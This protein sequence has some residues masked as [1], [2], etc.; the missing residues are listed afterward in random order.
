MIKW[1]QST[2][3]SPSFWRKNCYTGP[4]NSDS[5]EF[6]WFLIFFSKDDTK[7]IKTETNHYAGSCIG[8]M[9]QQNNNRPNS[10]WDK[11]SAVT[12]KDIYHFFV[13]ILHLC[14]VKTKNIL[15][16]YWP[17]DQFCSCFLQSLS[18]VGVGQ[19]NFLSMLHMNDNI[20]YISIK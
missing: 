10:L 18:F 3:L 8:K 6:D 17:T 11:W 5:S 7:K 13:I 19:I 16:D 15:N 12:V 20:S 14:V 4:I 1:W 2:N 9:K